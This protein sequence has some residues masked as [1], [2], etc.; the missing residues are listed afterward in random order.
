MLHELSV[1]VTFLAKIESDVRVS[2]TN[3]PSLISTLFIKVNKNVLEKYIAVLFAN[4]ARFAPASEP[5]GISNAILAVKITLLIA[6]MS[7]G[8]ANVS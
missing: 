5:A 4:E 8:I 6:S 1:S 7:S 2:T 3:P